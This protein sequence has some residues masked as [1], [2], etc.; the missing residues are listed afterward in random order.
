MQ[1]RG[2]A[3]NTDVYSTKKSYGMVT[4]RH[5]S[6]NARPVP[7]KWLSEQLSGH[8]TP[9]STASLP[10]PACRLWNTDRKI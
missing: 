2:Q 10:Y 6:D 7:S 1:G 5:E 3:K 4:Q 8:P 9:R